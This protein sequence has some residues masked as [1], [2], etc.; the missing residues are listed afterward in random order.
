MQQLDLLR[1]PIGSLIGALLLLSGIALLRSSWMRRNGSSALMTGGWVLVAAGFATFA[2]AWGGEAG[3]VY[4]LVVFS[5]VAYVV[6]AMG[7]ELRPARAT[8][9]RDIALE[10]EDGRRT[11]PALLPRACSPSC[12]PA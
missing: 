12:L 3:T 2:Y 5:A 10:P 6:V 11:G 8:A 7:V 9:N 1:Q 4:A